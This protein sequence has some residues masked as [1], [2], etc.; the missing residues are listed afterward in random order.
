MRATL[1]SHWYK[2]KYSG[3]TLLLLPL[4]WIFRG[5]VALRYFLYRI[6]LLRRITLP[7]PVIV[8]GNIT[9]GGTG[10]TPFVIWLAA[11]LQAQGFRP[12]IVSR[13]VGGKQ[14]RAPR[15]VSAT[16]AVTDV[17][18]EAVLLLQRT[19]CPVVVGIDR[20]AAARY[21]L[22]QNTCNI[23]ISDDGLQHYRLQRTLEI[24]IVDGVRQFGNGCLLPA[25]PLREPPS[26]LRR[27]DL[28]I[29]TGRDFMLAADT[30]VAVCNPATRLAVAD[31]PRSMVHAVA[32][33][34]HPARFF[35]ALQREGFEVMPHAFPDHYLYRR[36]DIYFND[37]LPVLMTEKDAVKCKQFADRRHWYLQVDG[38]VAPTV[39]E[40]MR[41]SIC[42]KN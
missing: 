35:N 6:G 7:V 12:G 42:I 16:S 3:L 13:G 36:Q 31:F 19:G 37:D 4:S 34:G 26:R 5:V 17:G 33:I 21:L 1:E 14:Q 30:L 2:K 9:T 15:A 29:E 10:K 20:V 23:I 28:V 39:L 22:Q 32:G 11:W 40:K 18:D 25:G 38:H 8:V 41:K 24:A 27:V